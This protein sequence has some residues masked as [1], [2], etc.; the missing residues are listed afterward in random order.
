M[1]QITTQQ[2][3]DFQTCARLYDYRYNQK[4]SETIGIRTLNSTRF[5]NTIKGIAHYFF[6]KKQAGIT[7]SYASLLNRWEKLWFPKGASSQ[8]I[9]YEQHETLYG[10]AS[11]LTTKAAAVLLGLFQTFGEM[12]IIPIGIDEEFIAPINTNISIKDRFDLIYYKDGNIHVLKWMFNY[13]LKYQH[14]YALDFSVMQ[15]GINNKFGSKVKNVKLGYFDLMDQK[16][17]FNQ[18]SIEKA[19][20]DAI[21]YWCDSLLEEKVFPSRRGLTSYCKSCPFDKPCSKWTSW[22]KKEK[23]NAKKRKK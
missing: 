2:L 3:K 21:G 12:D 23:T 17:S 14:T 1:I 5:E 16:S 11:S 13:K 22:N 4:L 18:F 19:D 9:I 7:P 20:T 15:I 10:N 8:D 6:Y